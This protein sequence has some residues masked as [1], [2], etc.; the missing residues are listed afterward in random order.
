MPL[1][2][3]S[4]SALVMVPF[5]DGPWTLGSGWGGPEYPPSGQVRVQL[6]RFGA[7]DRES[8]HRQQEGEENDVVRNLG[9]RFQSS[10]QIGGTCSCRARRESGLKLTGPRHCQRRIMI[11]LK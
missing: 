4:P 10:H 3:G 2:D 6:L 9:R 1:R 7:K 8:V 5:F 11:R